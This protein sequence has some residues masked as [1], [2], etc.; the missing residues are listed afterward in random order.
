ME[1]KELLVKLPKK[2]DLSCSENWRGITLLP[3]ASKILCIVLLN[4]IKD[5]EDNTLR[6]KQ[7]GFRPNRSCSDQIAILTIS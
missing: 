7:A 4:R 1:Y 2:E 5:A 6:D 3:V